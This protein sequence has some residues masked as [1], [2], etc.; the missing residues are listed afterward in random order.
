MNMENLQLTLE[1]LSSQME[2]LN[3]DFNNR[4][5]NLAKRVCKLESE[6][7][8]GRETG[9]VEEGGDSGNIDSAMKSLIINE[10][11]KTEKKLTV[12]APADTQAPI[13]SKSLKW[14]YEALKD[15]VNRIKLPPRYRMND[16]KAG[17]S[18]KDR[19]HA[20]VIIKS[21]KFL[22]TTLKH[23]FEI[24]RNWGKWTEVADLLDGVLLASTAHL[25]YLQEEHNSLY[26]AGQYGIQAKQ[27][28]RSIQRNTSNLQPEDVEYLKMTVSILPPPQQST[29]SGFHQRG[30]SSFRQQNQ[31][32]RG[33]RGGYRG[34]G[35]NNGFS[36]NNASGGATFMPRQVPNMR[37]QNDFNQE[38]N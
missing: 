36:Y 16:S 30:G 37:E 35:G 18:P 34:R 24:Q 3:T 14:E 15:A 13:S 1:K 25:R 9:D 21:G 27:I 22:E 38:E 7:M 5:D 33:Y 29:S 32:A 31:R 19:E 4:C 20:A 26:V 17:I 12:D 28:F 23:L 8:Q 6:D 2:K 10:S 11:K